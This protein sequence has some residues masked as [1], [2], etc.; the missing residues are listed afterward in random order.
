[1]LYRYLVLVRHLIMTYNL[2]PAGSHGVWGL[3]DHSFIPFIFGSAQLAP[4]IP[5]LSSEFKL[6]QVPQEGSLP[7]AALPS[8]VTRAAAVRREQNSNMYFSAVGFIYDVKKGPFWE[9]SPV[10][11]DVSGITTGWAKVNKGMLKMYN[12][13][14]LSKFPVIQHFPF[15]SLFRWEAD[16]SAP[17]PTSSV[18]SSNQPTRAAGGQPGMGPPGGLMSRN[19]LAG[20]ATVNPDVGPVGAGGAATR[21]PAPQFGAM[22]PAQH[23]PMEQNIPRFET[24]QAPLRSASGAAAQAMPVTQAPWARPAA[25]AQT[26]K[27][28][29]EMPATKAPWADGS[30]PKR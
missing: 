5:P 1:M 8:D 15:G 13:E 21:M 16:P 19:P 29:G 24:P 30:L 9:H 20:R 28:P 14:V 22:R 4:P 12:V 6:E 17:P 26:T 23:L 18:H 3:D 25:G 27:Q 10:L 2:E 11:Y 7:G